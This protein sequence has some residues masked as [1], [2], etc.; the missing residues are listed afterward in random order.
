MKCDAEDCNCEAI[1]FETYMD[2][3]YCK[4]CVDCSK[5]VIEDEDADLDW[6]VIS[7]REYIA[8]DV[9]HA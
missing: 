2:D 1:Y 3:T 6:K 5:V 9:M 7:K 8:A 4:W